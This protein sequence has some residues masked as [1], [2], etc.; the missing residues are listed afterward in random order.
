MKLK[1]ILISGVGMLALA[2]CGDYLDVDSPS[3][4]TTDITFGSTSAADKALNGVYADILS[5]NS[6]GSKLYNSLMLNSDV[7]FVSNASNTAQVNAPRRFDCKAESGEAEKLWDQLYKTIEDANEFIDN[8]QASAI[9]HGEDSAQLKQMVG[10]AKVIRAMCYSELVWYY[11]DVPFTMN[12]T[13]HDG[14]LI[15]AIESRDVVLKTVIED[16]I[17]AAEGMNNN[18]TVEHITQDAAYAMIAR[19]ALQAG[20]YSLRHNEDASSYGYMARPENYKEFYTIARDYAKKVIDGNRHDLNKSFQEVFVDECNFIANEGDDVIFEIPF[21]KESTGNVGYD[22]GPNVGTSDGVA[23]FDWGG[24]SGGVRTTAFL[25]YQYDENDSRRD[26]VCGMWYYTSAGVPTMQLTYANHNNKWSKLWSSTP[27][28]SDKTGSTGINFPYLRYADVLLMY[29]EAENEVNE[30]PTDEAYNALKKVHDRAFSGNETSSIEWYDNAMN[31]KE[32][33]LNAVLTERK[34]EFPGENMRWKDLVRNNQYSEKLFYTFLLYYSAA[35]TAGGA[36]DHY[37]DYLNDYDGIDYENV[38]P[39]EVYSCA[40]GTGSKNLALSY[41]PN[42]N[43]PKRF[44]LNPFS[45]IMMPTVNPS[46][47]ADS[48]P[49]YVSE[50]SLGGS[51]EDVWTVTLPFD[52]WDEELGIPK[53]AVLYSLFGFIQAD[54]RGIKVIRN[55]REEYIDPSAVVANPSSLPVVRYLLPIPAESISRSSG[56]YRNYYGY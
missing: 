53:D 3:S 39:F 35:A 37:Y 40:A 15:P 10:E 43:L 16:L 54:V 7:D 18:K 44:V 45:S 28:G 26:Y 19:L 33:F 21:A 14:V 25:R 5:D 27:F 2:S 24:C 6:F 1:N 12:A 4:S 17:V 41:F 42:D 13:F 46:K 9:Y 48:K 30:G 51:T 34:F 20:G 36:S 49:Y 52:W 32:D 55:G 38:L 31:S 47:Y 56:A 29:A 11:G 23:P 50:K 8:M 22:Q